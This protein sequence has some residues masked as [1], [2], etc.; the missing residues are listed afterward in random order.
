MAVT[1]YDPEHNQRDGGDSQE[2]S[3]SQN[4]GPPACQPAK[5]TYHRQRLVRAWRMM[6]PTQPPTAAAPVTAALGR[7]ALPPLSAVVAVVAPAIVPTPTAAPMPHAFTP[8]PRPC[9]NSLAWLS[10]A[11]VLPVMG[12]R[13]G[14]FRGSSAS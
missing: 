5:A 3:E 12:V 10:P 14:S 1:N 9:M 6:L 2:E 8:S 4:K 11:S 13:T 7:A